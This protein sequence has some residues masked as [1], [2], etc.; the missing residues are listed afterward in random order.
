MR[1]CDQR[2]SDRGEAASASLGLKRPGV[3][4]GDGAVLVQLARPAVVEQ[5]EGRVAVLLNLGE[6]D[7]GAYGVDGAGRDEDDVALLD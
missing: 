7:P 3:G 4:N 1:A 6:H 2:G 5:T